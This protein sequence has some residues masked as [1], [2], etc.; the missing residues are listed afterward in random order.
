MRD[1]VQAELRA[2]PRRVDVAEPKAE[3]LLPLLLRHATLS[4]YRASPRFALHRRR[5]D[6][7]RVLP[8]P[9]L[10]ERLALYLAS[11][12]P[13]SWVGRLGPRGLRR[14]GAL[15]AGPLEAFGR[16]ALEAARAVRRWRRGHDA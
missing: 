8:A 16:L 10:G 14:C 5:V 7:D 1:S 9:L 12:L 11:R 4:I 2:P 6:P 15:L 13:A 3:A